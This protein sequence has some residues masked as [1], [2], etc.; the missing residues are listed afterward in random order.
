M[1]LLG[2]VLQGFCDK[3]ERTDHGLKFAVTAEEKFKA[4]IAIASQRVCLLYTSDAADEE[5]V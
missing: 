1:H 2:T 4:L 3:L 5:D